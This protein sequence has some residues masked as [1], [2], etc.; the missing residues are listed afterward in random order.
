MDGGQLRET[1]LR[2][3]D[4]SRGQSSAISPCKFSTGARIRQNRRWEQVEHRRLTHRNQRGSTGV[5]QVEPESEGVPKSA[6]RQE[7]K[8]CDSPNA[9]SGW[10]QSLWPLLS[11]WDCCL[12]QPLHKI[13]LR[14]FMR[15]SNWTEWFLG[16]LCIL[17]R[18]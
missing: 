1:T 5:I 18:C 2:V 13:R 4:R 10:Q 14:H 12:P 8:K 6:N 15:R 7:T 9:G 3:C 16:S 17:I 11:Y